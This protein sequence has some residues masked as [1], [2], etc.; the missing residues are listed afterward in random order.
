MF[1]VGN[2]D[3]DIQG[4]DRQEAYQQQLESIFGWGDTTPQTL[5]T[6]E[7]IWASIE[8]T[9]NNLAGDPDRQN[10]YQRYIDRFPDGMDDMPI[11]R[12]GDHYEAIGLDGNFHE[13]DNTSLRWYGGL[14]LWD[15]LPICAFGATALDC[16]WARLG[17]ERPDLDADG[18][19]DADDQALFDAAWTTYAPGPCDGGNAWCDG[20]DLDRSGALDADDEDFM[21]AAQGC[22]YE[23]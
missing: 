1:G 11:R 5:K 15:E 14:H 19:A 6:D 8:N 23:V 17:C 4:Y 13:I 10:T 3:F 21:T 9:L 20:A 7:Q 18:D 16:T 22:W 12:S 2:E